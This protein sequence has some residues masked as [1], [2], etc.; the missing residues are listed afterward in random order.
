[1]KVLSIVLTAVCCFVSNVAQAQVQTFAPGLFGEIDNWLVLYAQ[2]GPLDKAIQAAGPEA[3]FAAMTDPKL[4]PVGGHTLDL[5]GLEGAGTPDPKAPVRWQTA[6]A[7]LPIYRNIWNTHSRLNVLLDKDGHGIG[8]VAYCYCR[9]VAPEDMTASLIGGIN[10]MAAG[11]F[12][13]NGKDLGYKPSK[14][15]WEAENVAELPIELKKGVNHLLIRIDGVHGLSCRLVGKNAE[16]LPSV[17]LEYD[18]APGAP[19]ACTTEAPDPEFTLTKLAAQIPPILPAEHPELLGV[20][21]ARTM[22]LLE[23]GKYTHRPVRI[24]FYGQSIE[25]GWPD[26]LIQRLRERY[27]GTTIEYENRALGGWFVWR[28]AKAFKHD[29]LRWQPDLVLMSAYQGSAAVWERFLS[30][31]RRETTADIIIRSQH[32]SAGDKIDNP[33]ENP[34]PIFLRNLAQKYDAEFIEVTSEWNEYLKANKVAIK[35]L[36]GDPVHPNRKGQ[37][38]MAE[39]YDRHF[40]TNAASRQGWA[41]TVRRFDVMRFW[42]QHKTDEIVL[43][44]KGWKA[45][46]EGVASDSPADSLKLKFTGTR[47]DLVLLP[48]QGA[49]DILI[50]GKKPSEFKLFHGTLPFARTRMQYGYLPQM[51]MGYHLGKDAQQETWTL[52]FTHVSTDKDML[53]SRFV[54]VGSKTGPDGEGDTDHDFV[55]TSGRISI[56]REDWFKAYEAKQDLNRMAASQ[57]ASQPTLAAAPADKQAQLVWHVLPDSMDTVQCPPMPTEKIEWYS[58]PCAYVTIFD[59]LP[60]GLHELTLTP[61]GG[62]PLGVLGLDVHR[63]PMARDAQENTQP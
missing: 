46:D 9:L 45:Q 19:A 8:G 51:M 11:K 5:P 42:E 61:R 33:A 25:A 53:H 62:A 13:L 59:G 57:P 23:T 55:S 3:K 18:A 52:T 7:T 49:A 41:N 24:M 27:P 15:L 58:R 30:D 63:P 10:H 39:L 4:I 21:I 16:P 47:V 37:T 2:P 43:A 50:D 60:C 17:K 14:T 31:L 34:E 38:L 26:M 44:G 56:D 6:R 54:V 12:Y 36:L 48:G 28:L 22:S 20:K 32:L 29:I 40:R 1:M 35:D